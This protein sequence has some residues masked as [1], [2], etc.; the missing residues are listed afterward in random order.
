MLEPYLSLCC[1]ENC[2]KFLSVLSF[3][4][5]NILDSK[6]FNTVSFS[7]FLASIKLE[8]NSSLKIEK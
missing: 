1:I 2:L 4:L 6:T 8:E 3:I 5:S 7:Y